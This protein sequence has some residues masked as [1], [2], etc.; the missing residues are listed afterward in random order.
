[1]WQRCNKPIC[2]LNALAPLSVNVGTGGLLFFF[3]I[4]WFITHSLLVTKAFSK[5]KMKN[6]DVCCYY[7]SN[8]TKNVCFLE[9]WKVTRHVAIFIDSG[10]NPLTPLVAFRMLNGTKTVNL[11]SL[12]KKDL[13]SINV[14]PNMAHGNGESYASQ[15][16]L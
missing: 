11:H 5:G 9:H 10:I 12:K 1:M 4:P 2:F 15:K 8:N 7:E 6:P 3:I 16:I 13:K 14:K